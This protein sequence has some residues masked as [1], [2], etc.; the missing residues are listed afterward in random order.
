MF[1]FLIHKNYREFKSLIKKAKTFSQ[2]LNDYSNSE[3]KQQT[4]KLQQKLANQ[5]SYEEILPEAF[6]TLRAVLCFIMVKLQK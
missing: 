2:I 6:G 3:L 1:N 5:I 4:K